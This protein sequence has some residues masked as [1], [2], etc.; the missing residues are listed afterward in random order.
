MLLGYLVTRNVIPLVKIVSRL[1]TPVRRGF[2][3]L[4]N[5]GTRPFDEINYWGSR[6]G[7]RA[8]TPRRMLRWFDRSA[9]VMLIDWITKRGQAANNTRPLSPRSID[10]LG[11]GRFVRSTCGAQ[12]SWF[13]LPG[14]WRPTSPESSPLRR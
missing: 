11:I 6:A 9:A 4:L 10:H 7:G 2:G 5:V 13:N 1:P 14:G 8:L 3:A 12:R